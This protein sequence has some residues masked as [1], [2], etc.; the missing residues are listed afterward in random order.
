[1]LKGSESVNLIHSDRDSRK[2]FIW[3]F[4]QTFLL[5]LLLQYMI[6]EHTILY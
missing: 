5:D 6:H 1:M 2:N 3:F 4:Q